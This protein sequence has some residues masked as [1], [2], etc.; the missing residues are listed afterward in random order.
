MSRIFR[1]NDRQT[2]ITLLKNCLGITFYKLSNDCRRCS[3]VSEESQL[4]KT[5]VSSNESSPCTS[6]SNSE[7]ESLKCTCDQLNGVELF[8][9][10][11]KENCECFWN[12]SLVNGISGLKYKGFIPPCTLFM[13]GSDYTYEVIRTAWARRVIKSPQGYSILNLGE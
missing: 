9:S 8:E 10:F 7:Q 3:L 13:T 11:V 12:Q 6:L 4:V 2:H 1:T 5:Q